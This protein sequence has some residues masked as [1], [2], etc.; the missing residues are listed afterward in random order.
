MSTL[1]APAIQICAFAL[2]CALI[3]AGRRHA[4]ALTAVLAVLAVL[5]ALL[6]LLGAS[7]VTAPDADAAI[8]DEVALYEG[9]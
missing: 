9:I 1:S 8:M 2:G 4:R 5:A 6:V 7:A 3:H